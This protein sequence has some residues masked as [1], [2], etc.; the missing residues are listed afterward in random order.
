VSCDLKSFYAGA[1]EPAMSG[2]ISAV[3][4]AATGSVGA[5]F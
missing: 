4:A 2:H 1:T 5:P 3:N